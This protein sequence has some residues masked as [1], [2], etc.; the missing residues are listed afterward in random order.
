MDVSIIIV[1]YN[2]C[3]LLNAC[4]KS[5]FS[6]TT[7]ID[8]EVIVSDN[9]S[10]DNSVP[11]LKECYPQVR[12]IDNK[13][14]LGFGAANNRGLAIAQG[15]YVFYLNSDTI[16]LNNAVKIF[17]DYWE[18]SD[19]RDQL[20]ALGCNLLDKDGNVMHSYGYF[21]TFKSLSM[22]LIY[23]NFAMTAKAFLKILKADYKKIKKRVPVE[24]KI[25]EVDYITGA[26]LFLLNNYSALYDERYFLYTEE[27]DLE[28]QLFLNKK[29]RLLIDGPLIIHLE[30]GSDNRHH[31]SL[32]SEYASFGKIQLDVSNLI[33]CRK[34]KGRAGTVLIK[35]LTLLNWFHPV[36]FGN[37][38]N[39]WTEILKI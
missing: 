6:M 21:P 16:L 15:K 27:T 25:G 33:F 2:T 23:R 11:M 22:S 37:A 12:L 7:K 19:Y 4:L 14:N 31:N 13:S 8:Y 3:N 1:N 24:K 17:F 35:I 20:G 29:K 38:R 26:D 28:Y 36:M 5:V 39:R 9:G 30:G 18:T 34:W 10:I 32:K